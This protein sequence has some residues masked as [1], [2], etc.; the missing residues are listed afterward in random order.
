MVPKNGSV[1]ASTLLRQQV[2]QLEPTEEVTVIPGLLML[3]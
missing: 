3:D 1:C 2:L